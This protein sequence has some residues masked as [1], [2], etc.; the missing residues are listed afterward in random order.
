MAFKFS[1]SLTN[2]LFMCET[3]YIFFCRFTAVGAAVEN[4][5]VEVLLGNITLNWVMCML[6]NYIHR[7]S[8]H[9]QSCIILAI[10]P[11]CSLSTGNLISAECCV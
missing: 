6:V 9:R 3:D 8:V 11:A 10:E 4:S 2:L 1:L 5:S 7:N